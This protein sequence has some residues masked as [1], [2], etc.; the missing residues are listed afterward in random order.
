MTRPARLLLIST[1]AACSPIPWTAA[2]EQ[3]SDHEL[4]L[5]SGGA[6]D[7]WTLEILPAEGVP[8][9]SDF[10]AMR[11]RFELRYPP[12]DWLDVDGGDDP[13]AIAVSATLDYPGGPPTGAERTL[14]PSA[15]R[16][17]VGT[18]FVDQPTASCD[19]FPVPCDWQATLDL[20]HTLP[21]AAIVDLAVIIETD[22]VVDGPGDP[23][24]T[25]RDARVQVTAQ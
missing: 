21:E 18:F 8:G 1:L 6:T 23:A 20:A 4:T 11:F 13:E 10:F 24:P 17:G 16:P 15:T 3:R 22:W 2:H 14:T 5:S 19:P 12:P 7:S 25:D 9:S